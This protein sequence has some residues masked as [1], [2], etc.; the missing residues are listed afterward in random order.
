[1]ATAH[2]LTSLRTL[3]ISRCKTATASEGRS[4]HSSSS[5]SLALEEA[6]R[7]EQLRKIVNNITRLYALFVL[8]PLV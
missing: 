5:E 1:M 7:I 2:F 8:R 6:D 3:S 4:L